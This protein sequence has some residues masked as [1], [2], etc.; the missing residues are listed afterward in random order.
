M[1]IT[2][3]LVAATTAGLIGLGAGTCAVIAA[4][5]KSEADQEKVEN[6][7]FM[8]ARV[9]LSDAVKAAEAKT[10]GR[11]IEAKLHYDDGMLVYKLETLT[12]DGMEQDVK[13]D[14]MDATKVSVLV[15]A[16]KADDADEKGD[17]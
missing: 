6:A 10:S 4:D 5:Q 16:G 15:E 3:R 8:T 9:T 1:K 13:V 2:K 7:A 12:S 17:D 14:A 11:A